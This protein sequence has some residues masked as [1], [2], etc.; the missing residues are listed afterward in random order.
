MSRDRKGFRYVVE[1]IILMMRTT[2]TVFDGSYFDIKTITGITYHVERELPVAPY[3][4]G[5]HRGKAR[6]EGSLTSTKPLSIGHKIKE[7]TFHFDGAMDGKT[8]YPVKKILHDVEITRIDDTGE[9]QSVCYFKAS[10]VGP[11][12]PESNKFTVKK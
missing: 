8:D 10:E 1:W 6:I 5:R 12:I 11:S 4:D 3:N 7:L 2:F 9:N